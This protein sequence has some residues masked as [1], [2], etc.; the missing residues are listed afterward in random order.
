MLNGATPPPSLPI[1][2][3][4]FSTERIQMCLEENK[5]LILAIMEN[6]NQ[7]KFNECAPYRAKLQNNLM[8]LSNLADTL[9]KQ[10]DV[11]SPPQPQMQAQSTMQQ[12][13]HHPQAAMSQ[14]LQQQHQQQQ[15]QQQQ[16]HQ[17]QQQQQA[18][19]LQQQQFNQAQKA[20]QMGAGMGNSQESLGAGHAGNY[21]GK[22]GFG[23]DG[24][25]NFL[26]KS[27][28]YNHGGE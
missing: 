24:T 5:E 21:I 9:T 8:F 26:G 12:L 13:Q 2:N 18:L 23:N 16:Q 1:T 6:Q 25:S 7:G 28:G 27:F 17:H 4:N 3:F 22:P 14:Q 15:Q 20:M 19:F 11:V 10:P